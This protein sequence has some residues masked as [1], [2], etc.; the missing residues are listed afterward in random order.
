MAARRNNTKTSRPGW[1]VAVL[2]A[3]EGA[4]G[5]VLLSALLVLTALGGVAL[6]LRRMESWVATLPQECP[7]VR[8]EWADLPDW[9]CLP[10]NRHVLDDLM[11]CTGVTEDDRLTEPG[12]AEAVARKLSDP[13][14]AWVRR[15][16]RV[17]KRAPDALVIRCEFRRPVAW[18]RVEGSD[19]LVDAEGVRLPG[20]YKRE[21]LD[22][23]GLPDVVGVGGGPPA[24]GSYWPGDEI[25]AGLAVL[26][27]VSSQPFSHQI[28]GV[29]VE[30]YG[31]RLRGGRSHLDLLTNHPGSRV[32]WGRP[33]GEEEA[34]EISA[35]RKVALMNSM[36]EHNGR[37]DMDRGYVDITTWPDRVVTT[38]DGLKPPADERS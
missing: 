33:P 19:Y 37:V 10:D 9:L 11:A 22:G 34:A 36:F 27:R 1:T 3:L 32:Q 7:P 24:V 26:R 12:L 15:V 31:S 20:R 29:S 28:S 17:V 2:D 16:V 14:V 35:D 5:R 8:I 30:N 23:S 13:S 6:G 4:A 25:R 38:T 21:S 18:V